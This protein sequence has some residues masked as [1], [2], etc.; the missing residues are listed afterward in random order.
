MDRM[1]LSLDE[2]MAAKPK[3]AKKI[4]V[5][6]KGKTVAKAKKNTPVKASRVTKEKASKTTGPAVK[7]PTFTKTT[8]KAPAVTSASIFTRLGNA[9]A[10]N[11]PSGALVLLSKLNRNITASDIAELVSRSGETRRVELKYDNNGRPLGKAEV[12]F[13]KQSDAV[14]CV[15]MLNGV[16]L[17]G[18]PMEVKL[19]NNGSAKP[20]PAKIVVAVDGRGG[21]GSQKVSLVQP[22]SNNN[23]NNTKPS[24]GINA[25]RNSN[26]S[27]QSTK[28][29]AR[30]GG[31]GAGERKPKGG[32]GAGASHPDRPTKSSA[33]LDA[34]MDAYM[35]SK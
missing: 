15:K 25:R 3:P 24:N 1:N 5:K 16:T 2:I 23:K 7:K 31:R 6:A 14:G 30:K 32:R 20:S 12:L 28:P 8:V 29:E 19:V 11:A 17:D 26:G 35:S 10:A 13:A 34:E 18:R 21:R 4:A 22:F 27:G 33:D 9:G